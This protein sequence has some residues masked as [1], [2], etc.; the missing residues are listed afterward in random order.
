MFYHVTLKKNLK[1]ILENGL[2]PS[3]I[4]RGKGF[5]QIEPCV[6]LFKTIEEADDGVCNWLGDCFDENDEL[7]LLEISELTDYEDDP[8]LPLSAVICFHS[9][10]A[11]VIKVI[12]HNY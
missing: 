3:K 2:K 9:I 7:V 12:N 6:Y 5:E 4:K 11:S 10:P 8:E 1:S